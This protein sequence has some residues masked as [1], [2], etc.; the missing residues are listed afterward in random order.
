MGR[1]GS[2]SYSEL[3]PAALGTTRSRPLAEQFLVGVGELCLP[4][5]SSGHHPG[6]VKTFES[7][8]GGEL[9]SPLP[10]FDRGNGRYSSLYWRNRERFSTHRLNACVFTQPAPFSTQSKIG[11]RPLMV[12]ADTA[13]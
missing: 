5:A 8:Q 9:F 3:S 1:R 11:S 12:T 4:P 7:Q 10:F 13:P 6:C 2:G